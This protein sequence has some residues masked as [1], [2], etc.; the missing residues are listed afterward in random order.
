MPMPHLQRDRP[1]TADVPLAI[2][3]GATRLYVIL[4]DPVAQVQAPRLMNRLFHDE[5]R[6]AVMLP[7]HV[8]PREL[9]SVMRGLRDIRNLDGILVT[10]PHKFAVRDFVDRPSDM[11][12]LTGAVNALRRDADGGWSGENFDGRG[13]VAGLHDQGHATEG[14]RAALVGTGGAGVA[15]GAALVAAGVRSLAVTDLAPDKAIELVAR[16]DTLR[17]GVARFEP[18]IDWREVDL[19]INATPLGLRADDPLPFDVAALR[20]DALVAE[21]IMKPARTALL[22]AAARRGLATQPG[23]HMLAS[24]IALYR[25]FFGLDG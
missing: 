19:A 6:D 17:P 14:R 25:T 9:A 12:R 22:E 8:G 2:S 16:L 4:G 15:I 18:V 21:V 13:F 24:Q 5:H 1:E 3:G 23:L 7:V 20:A 11:V 10:I